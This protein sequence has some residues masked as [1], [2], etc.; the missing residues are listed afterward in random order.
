MVKVSLKV[1]ED[2]EGEQMYNSTLPS[3]SGLD[4]TW[5]VNAMHRPLYP[6]ES[7]PVPIV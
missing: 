5:V 2:P 7:D 4:G 6:R 3:T 1:N